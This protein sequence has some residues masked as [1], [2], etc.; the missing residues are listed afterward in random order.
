MDNRC[1]ECGDQFVSP[2]RADYCSQRC[3]VAAW[4]RKGG[5]AT[6]DGLYGCSRCKKLKAP[7]AFYPSQL[8]MPG[9]WCK[10]CHNEHRRNTRAGLRTARVTETCLHCGSDIRHMRAHAKY[11]STSCGMKA[12][13]D[14]NPGRRREYLIK[15]LYGMT[16]SDFERMFD[17]QGRACAICRMTNPETPNG[18]R[19]QW[20][21]DHCHATGAIRGILCSKCNWG[22]GMFNEDSTVMQRAIHYL[23]ESKQ[24]IA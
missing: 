3:A 12:H 1:V 11:C 4:K 14:R 5:E 6:A 15:C 21:V 19:Q 9:R 20:N 23:Q 22:L 13:R 17:A 24:Q 8:Q 18:K 7:G 2:R 16:H 10:R